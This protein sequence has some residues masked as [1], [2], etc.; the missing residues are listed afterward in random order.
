MVDKILLGFKSGKFE[1][2]SDKGIV[3]NYVGAFHGIHTMATNRVYASHLS[4]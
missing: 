2:L 4:A 3:E 1:T